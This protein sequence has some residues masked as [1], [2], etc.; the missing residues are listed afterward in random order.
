MEKEIYLNNGATSYPKPDSVI[1]ALQDSLLTIPQGRGNGETKS[2]KRCKENI[3]NF[4][5]VDDFRY[6]IYSHNV[7][8]AINLFFKGTL[9]PGMRIAITIAEHASII[10]PLHHLS[11]DIGLD[12]VT[13]PLD[14][15]EHVDLESLTE[16]NSQ[17]QID[18]FFFTHSSNVTGSVYDLDRIIRHCNELNIKTGVDISQ[19][20]GL[21]PFN[22]NEIECDAFFV[23][24][25]KS[26]L[27]PVGIGLCF[28]RDITQVQPVL[29]GG[30]G[31]NSRTLFQPMDLDERF[32]VGTP[33][34]IGITGLSASI[35]Y[36]RERISCHFE[37]KNELVHYTIEKLIQ[38]DDISLYSTSKKKRNTGVVSFNIKGMLSVDIAELLAD[39]GII[40]R[41]GMHCAPLMHKHLGTFPNGCVRASFGHMTTKE[42]INYLVDEVKRIIHG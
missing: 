41:G 5:G 40:V 1:K 19:T 33:N 10:R 14:K 4:F 24:G 22:A 29:Y 18:W 26:L 34:V 16:I 6:F 25:H 17:K 20:A 38:F 9:K 36:V 27:G 15:N 8:Y 3:A 31:I 23:T 35:D 39:R 42:D 28:V 32:E 30:T 2:I 11:E 7:S 37:H 12:L 13:I 21:I